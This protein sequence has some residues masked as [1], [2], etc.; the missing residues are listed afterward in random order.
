MLSCNTHR[1]EQAPESEGGVLEGSVVILWLLNITTALTNIYIPGRLLLSHIL[2]DIM[3]LILYGRDGI[4]FE[5]KI[6]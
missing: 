2:I 4:L 3:I 6:T 1:N 5:Y